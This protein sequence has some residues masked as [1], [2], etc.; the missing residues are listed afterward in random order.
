LFD[1]GLGRRRRFN[2]REKGN[3]KNARTKPGDEAGE[4]FPMDWQRSSSSTASS[5]A[6]V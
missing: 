5:S 2:A 3:D 6:S 1:R 4:N